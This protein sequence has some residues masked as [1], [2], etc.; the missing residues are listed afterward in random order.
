MF[1]ILDE[2]PRK[3]LLAG[4]DD[5]SYDAETSLEELAQLVESAG[6]LPVARVLQK[7]QKPDVATCLGSG[8]LAEMAALIEQQEISMTVLDLELTATQ[9]RNL[10]EKLGC[11]V[12][13]RTMLI[14]EIFAQ[15]AHTAEGQ[16]QVELAELRYRLPRLAGRGK[17]LSRMGGGGGGGA[18]ARRGGGETKLETDRRHIRR[19]ITALEEQLRELTHRRQLHRQRRQKEQVTTVAIVGYTNVGKST[20]LNTLTGAGVLAEN[21]LFATLDPTARSL[22]LPDGRSVLL[23]DTVGLVSRLPHHLVDAFRSTL[24]EAA[25]AD[26]I[27]NVCDASSPHFED[28]Q[29]VTLELLAELGAGSTPVLSLL[30]KCDLVAC[31]PLEPS[32]LVAP[33]SA[34]TGQGLPELL[35]KIVAALPPRHHRMHLLLPYAQAALEA[36]ILAGGSILSRDYTEEGIVL[37]ALVDHSLLHEAAPF[38][39]LTPPN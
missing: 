14:L 3:V 4:L 25:Q 22:Q 31:P 23:I 36:R 28:Q 24:E 32:A 9:L 29:Q 2:T 35:E 11:D 8:R 33:I 10:E 20:L 15:R 5:G 26:L 39:R 6:G 18:G 21:K 27:L 34:A 12:M 19:R 17:A 1:D 7:R 38:R 13:D 16:L 30:N 37:E